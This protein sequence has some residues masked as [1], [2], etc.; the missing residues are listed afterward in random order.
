MKDSM[1]AAAAGHSHIRV[2]LIDDRPVI[3]AALRLLIE[4]WPGMEIVADA[5]QSP[6]V[7][8]LAKSLNPDI[9]LLELSPNGSQDVLGFLPGL[10]SVVGEG[11][12]IAL[13]SVNDADIRM[14]AVRLGA[15]GIVYVDKE[16]DEL[17]KA[18][19][20][21]HS[22]E[23]WLDHSLTAKL[24]AEIARPRSEKKP[25]AEEARI[26]ALTDREREIALLVCQGLKN[27]DIAQRLF[28]SE[29]TVRHHLTSI[30]AKLETANRFELLFFLYRHKVAP[31]PA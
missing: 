31:P 25:G 5:G 23:L 19:R 8:E 27:R 21:V 30:F 16:A 17:R 24:L 10:V 11:R 15:H 2:L 3:R 14:R 18:I 20:K 4:S 26:A 6:R 22:G 1:Q 28:I 9:V 7:L 13:T 12:I 29:T